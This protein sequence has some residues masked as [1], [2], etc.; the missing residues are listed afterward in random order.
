LRKL[1]K[2]A[3]SL[4]DVIP[5]QQIYL[6]PT[7]FKISTVIIK[8]IE[9]NNR[10]FQASYKNYVLINNQLVPQTL[11]FNVNDGTNKIQITLNY[12]KIRLDQPQSYPF[13]ILPEYKQVDRF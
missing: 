6:D 3:D 12:S 2:E 8:E 1:S 10:I 5:F 7:S 9:N 13:N 4:K 11:E